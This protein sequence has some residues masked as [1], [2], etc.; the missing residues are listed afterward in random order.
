MQFWRNDSFWAGNVAEVVIERPFSRNEFIRSRWMDKKLT[1]FDAL[2]AICYGLLIWRNGG[3][4]LAPILAGVFSYSLLR[5]LVLPWAQWIAYIKLEDQ[6]IF[7]FTD[8]RLTSVTGDKSR[9][10]EWSEFISSVETRNF[11][12]LKRGFNQPRFTI[13]KDMITN[14]TDEATLRRLLRSNTRSHLRK[15]ESLD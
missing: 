5:L 6:P 12:S 11:Y 4:L 3:A 1:W 14:Q 15:N 9:S 2:C 10:S 13:S 8:Q 7:K